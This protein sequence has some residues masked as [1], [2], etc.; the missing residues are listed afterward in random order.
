MKRWL[1]KYRPYIKNKQFL[2]S[3]GAAF[4][5]FIAGVVITYFAII[6]A[7][8]SASGPVT[9][10]IL[11]NIPVFDVDGLFVWGPVIFWLIIT[12]YAFLHPQKLPFMLKSIA[13]FLFIRSAFI[14]LTHIGPFPTHLQ[15]NGSGILGVFTTGSDLF[16]SS[17]TG[18]PFLMALTFWDNKYLRFFCLISS[19]FFGAVVLMAHLH[20][21][22]DVFAAFFITFAIFHIA[23]KL[24]KK[25]SQIFTLGI[26]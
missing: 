23:K 4:L 10:I 26:E 2:I 8:E 1:I 20:Y 13:I 22:I 3:T 6:Y 21:S 16:F 17:H 19:L 12:L 7:T 5:F 15:I 9:D 11:S 24:F 25:D 14:I 18:L